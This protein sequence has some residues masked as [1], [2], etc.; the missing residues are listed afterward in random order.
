MTRETWSDI[1][2]MR[3]TG[4]DGTGWNA[5][6]LNKTF[7]SHLGDGSVTQD[8]VRGRGLFD[9]KRFELREAGHPADGL[10]HVPSLV[11]IDH[12]QTQEELSTLV[13][14]WNEHSNY[15]LVVCV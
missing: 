2:F 1:L 15:N 12:L 4:G 5:K 9:P 6:P 14:L 10:A 7:L 3:R 8:V 13:I 11:G